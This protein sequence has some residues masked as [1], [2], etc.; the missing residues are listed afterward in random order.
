MLWNV[1][2]PLKKKIALMS[3]FSLTVIIMGTAIARVSVTPTAHSQADVSWLYLWY[4]LEMHVGKQS[5][6]QKC[7]SCK[8]YPSD[9]IA[10]LLVSSLA[11]FRQLYVTQ[12]NNT[13]TPRVE[14]SNTSKVLKRLFSKEQ[15]HAYSVTAP[16][17][18]HQP[19]ARE[20][21]TLPLKTIHVTHH[22]GMSTVPSR[23]TIQDQDQDQEREHDYN[24]FPSWQRQV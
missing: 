5:P 7:P 14:S 2:V 15:S 13:R 17:P 18:V 19:K 8:V 12:S 1:R 10:A 9:S 20:E 22:A 23:D 11:A 21:D 3:L 4:N 24:D 6:W 16:Q